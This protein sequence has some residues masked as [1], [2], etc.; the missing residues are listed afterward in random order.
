MQTLNN[1]SLCMKRNEKSS[2]NV[3]L[4][5]SISITL[6]YFQFIVQ[7]DVLAVVYWYD[8]QLSSLITELD[9]ELLDDSSSNDDS[10]DSRSHTSLEEVDKL[11]PNTLLYKVIT[12]PIS[13]QVILQGVVCSQ[14]DICR[15]CLL[16]SNVCLVSYLLI[17][18]YYVSFLYLQAADAR[19]IPILL[20]ALANKAD[21][22]W[23]NSA[24]SNKTSL[25]KAVESV[26][27]VVQELSILRCV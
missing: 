3:K 21:I 23:K 18:A 13:M 8:Q 4:V 15:T 5:L 27:I 11:D 24:D 12:Q 26:S 14:A 22:N 9:N 25:I 16:Y 1:N 6:C 17:D 2:E 10:E 19:N 20:Q 7:L